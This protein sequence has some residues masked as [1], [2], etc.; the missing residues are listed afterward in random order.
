MAGQAYYDN[1]ELQSQC[2]AANIWYEHMGDVG[3]AFW[4]HNVMRF[5]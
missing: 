1:T 4:I 5:K 3:L 2:A